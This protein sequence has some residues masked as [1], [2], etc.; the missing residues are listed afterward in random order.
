MGRPA[1]LLLLLTLLVCMVVIAAPAQEAETSSYVVV[2]D[3]SVQAPR[4]VAHSQIDE[5]GGELGFVYRHAFTGYSAKL[6]E[7]AVARLRADPRVERIVKDHHVM[8]AE[9]EI[10]I[11]T[12]D[13]EW[14][15]PEEAVIPTGVSRVFATSN[16]ALDIDGQ[17]DVRADVDVA[18][19]DS[20]VD[21]SQPDLNVAGRVDCTQGGETCLPN[22]GTPGDHATHVAGIIGALDNG[23]GVVGMAPGARLWS[24]KVLGATGGDW[25]AVLAGIDWVAAHSSE[26]EV[27]N[28]SLGSSDEV[29]E[30]PERLDHAKDEGVV[31]VVAGGNQNSD[32]KSRA[33]GN[34]ESVITVSAI[35][36]YDGKA[37]GLAS[38]TCANFGQDDQRA[39][40]SNFGAGVDIAAPGVC[41]LSTEPNSGYGMK[42]GTSMAS[43]MVAG[44]AALLAAKTNP[45]SSTEVQAIRNLLI[46]KGNLDWTDTSGDGIKERLLDVHDESVFSLTGPP[47]VTTGPVGIAGTGSETQVSLTGTI[48]PKGLT[49]TYQFEYVSAAKYKPEAENPYAEGAKIP[50]SAASIGSGEKGQPLAVKQVPAGLAAGTTYHY[51]LV[52]ENSKGVTKGAD[53]VFVSPAACKGSEG[54]CSW[55]VQN[56]VAPTPE[57]NYD[58]EDV[59]CPTATSCV[60]VGFDGYH[61]D[62]YA[63]LWNGSAWKKIGSFPGALKAISC[64]TATWCMT[65][66]KSE[67]KGWRLESFEY[68]PG[69]PLWGTTQKAPPTPEGATEPKLQDVSCTSS[70]ACTVVGRYSVSGAEK[71]YVARWNGTAWSLQS[72]PSPA[73]G[74]AGE[75]MLG[76]SCA[77]TTYCVAVGTA[78]KKPFAERWNGSEWSIQS[79]PNPSGATEAKLKGVSCTS[80]SACMAVGYFKGASGPFKALS[81][82]WD[83]SIWA[84]LSHPAPVKEGNVMLRS[85]ACT[86]ATS[87]LAVGGLDDEPLLP[88]WEQSIAESWNGSS[89]A[90]QSSLNVEGKALTSFASVACSAATAC[91]AVGDSGPAWAWEGSNGTAALVERWNGSAWSFQAAIAPNPET[92]YEFEDVSCPG[93]TNCVAVGFDRYHEDGFAQQWNGSAWKKIGGFPGEMKAIS[94]PT[95]TWCMTIAKRETK[96]W[97]LEWFEYEPG[98]PIWGTNQKAPPTPEGATEVKLQDVSCTSSSA[99]TVVGRYK[100]AG[101]DKPYVARWNGTAWALQSAPSPAEGTATEAMLSVSCA[102]STYCVAVGTAAKRPFAERWNGSEWAIQTV[103]NPSGATEASL[104][105][106]SCTSSSACMAV[107]YF[108]GASGP[109]KA[110]SERWDG[111]SWT[112]LSHPAPSKEGSVELRSVACVSAASCLAVGGLDDMPLLPKWEQTVAQ[113]WNGVSWTVQ[114]PL[115]VEG[116]AVSSFSGVA[117]SAATACTAVGLSGPAWAWE[118]S[119][120]TAALVERLG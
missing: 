115:N 23:F 77:S 66:A 20:G 109:F 91:T 54:K 74:T 18:V 56:A 113:S 119:S 9:E 105:G 33:P 53:Q 41:L 107:G 79:V 30:L 75:A 94:C 93:A 42:S 12:F 29:F 7:Q 99:C 27:A 58:F 78:A 70:S 60:A 36:D 114:S 98:K 64:P 69:K 11:D 85:V 110:L 63:Q 100:A 118:G 61:E 44:A 117:C 57:T 34:V 3:D 52:A 96:G 1:Y 17:D 47:A 45:N 92:I 84:A 102:S 67:A 8:P 62:G 16:K 43:P 22:S 112:A 26:I 87:C 14:V 5:R 15:E 55:S 37:G 90:I 46:S 10:A 38:P 86:S 76:V 88:K 65:V 72:A 48:E 31:Y 106:V 104:K 103:P 89:W 108:K 49:T 81:E 40:F 13:D 2:L 39:S 120:G 32:V 35:A 71:P 83:G 59:S 19:L 80:S 97:K 68:E 21:P 4:H 50:L 24:V 51:R 111:G 6:P 73:E 95:G 25:T 116:K 28:M 101:T 82:R